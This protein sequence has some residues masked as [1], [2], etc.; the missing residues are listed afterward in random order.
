MQNVKINK[1]K[2][3]TGSVEWLKDQLSK[4]EFKFSH[5][6]GVPE[7]SYGKKYINKETGEEKVISWNSLVVMRGNS[8]MDMNLNDV[9]REYNDTWICYGSCNDYP[10]HYWALFPYLTPAAK[11]QCDRLIKHLADELSRKVANDRG[12]LK[13]TIAIE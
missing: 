8:E 10:D 5:R 13:I 4:M 12:E 2:P 9:C 1:D 6:N 7:I 3:F 11:E